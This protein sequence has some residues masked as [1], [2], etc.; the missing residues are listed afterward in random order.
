[1]LHRSKRSANLHQPHRPRSSVVHLHHLARHLQILIR[2]V[3]LIPRATLHQVFF[4]LKISGVQSEVVGQQLYLLTK[5]YSI[6]IQ[7]VQVMTFHK[8]NIKIDKQAIL[9]RTMKSFLRPE[10]SIF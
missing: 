5:E 8:C 2:Q 1:M 3:L 7:Y 9:L 4:L 10:G 6:S